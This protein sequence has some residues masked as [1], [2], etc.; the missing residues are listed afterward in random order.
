M[1]GIRAA[2]IL[3][4]VLGH[5]TYAGITVVD[6]WIWT[7][8]SSDYYGS[9]K[10]EDW[11]TDPPICSAWASTDI[12]GLPYFEG[13]SEASLDVPGPTDVTSRLECSVE[14][15]YDDSGGVTHHHGDAFALV[16]AILT[17]DMD[18]WWQLHIAQLGGT[19]TASLHDSQGDQVGTYNS[20]TAPWTPVNLAPGVYELQ[21]QHTLGVSVAAHA[22][23]P[24]VSSAG[25]A[26][27]SLAITAIPVPAA[28]PLAGLGIV[29]VGWL[30]RHSFSA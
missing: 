13:H 11:V 27:M 14:V 16:G 19:A 30:R 10:E 5:V 17:I 22:G 23:A 3:V 1:K 7:E 6:G 15:G 20:Q 28:F 2:L 9:D 8:V 4:F 29:V 12:E 21:V 24:W 18:H 26:E 25:S